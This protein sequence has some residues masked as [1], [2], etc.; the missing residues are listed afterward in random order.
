MPF[1]LAGRK[2]NYKLRCFECNLKE[3]TTG[4]YLCGTCIKSKASK[5]KEL[6]HW[7]NYLS[8]ATGGATCNTQQI[9]TILSQLNIDSSRG[10]FTSHNS[11]DKELEIKTSLLVLLGYPHIYNTIKKPYKKVDGTVGD[12]ATDSTPDFDYSQGP[13]TPASPPETIVHNGYTWYISKAS[14][15]AFKKAGF[16]RKSKKSKSKKSK[17]SK[18]KLFKS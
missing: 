15:K 11:L 1:A 5:I 16:G 13:N 2:I 9:T 4:F 14:E 10:G 6:Q 18:K 17:K 3:P 7:C 12:A 8:Q